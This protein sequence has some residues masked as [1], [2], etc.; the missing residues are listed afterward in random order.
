VAFRALDKKSFQGRLLHIIAAVDKQNN[1]VTTGGT[2]KPKTL[3]G[4]RDEKRKA[5]AG[6]EFNWSVLYMNVS[7]CRC[8]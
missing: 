2:S 7:R 8:L 5:A 3:K 1:A 4:Q 6:K